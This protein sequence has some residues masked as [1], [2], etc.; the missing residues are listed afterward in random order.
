MTISN[1]KGYLSL[2]REEQSVFPFFVGVRFIHPT[3]PFHRVMEYGKGLGWS[4]ELL[5]F[6][7][8][9]EAIKD[10]PSINRVCGKKITPQ[11][12]HYAAITGQSRNVF[13]P[14]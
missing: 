6:D 11:G 12:K 5:K 13:L 7:G 2:T 9:I 3:V 8:A 4:E 10:C 1:L 14:A